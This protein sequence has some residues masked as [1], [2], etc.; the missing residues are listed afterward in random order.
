[1]AFENLVFEGELAMQQQAEIR[2]AAGVWQQVSS[3][4]MGTMKSVELVVASLTVEAVASSN[5]SARHGEGAQQKLV[6]G[7][8]SRSGTGVQV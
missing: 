2:R 5:T 7:G 4:Q 1:M 6:V 3:S 8:G